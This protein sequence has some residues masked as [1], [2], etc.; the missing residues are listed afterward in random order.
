MSI[1]EPSETIEQVRSLLLVIREALRHGVKKAGQFFD[2]EDSGST[3]PW[4]AAH[5]VRWHAKTYLD[6]AGHTVHD[7][8]EQYGREHVSF[9]GLRVVYKNFS[10]IIRKPTDGALP[11]PSSDVQRDW[12]SHNQECFEF[13][14]LPAEPMTHLA[15]LWNADSKY[16]ELT[17]LEL[18]LPRALGEAYWYASILNLETVEGHDD[19]PMGPADEQQEGGGTPDA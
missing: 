3:D 15:V 13:M 16:Q 5:L 19:L 9:S 4:L 17:S 12:H 14:N 18:A 11:A 1:P 8:D 10:I 2:E 6:G 7:L